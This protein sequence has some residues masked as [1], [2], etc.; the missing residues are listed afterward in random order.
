MD[1]RP[2]AGF[3]PGPDT[4]RVS[5]INIEWQAELG[6]C[7][8][9]KLPVAMMWVDTTLAGLISGIQAMVGT[10]RYLLALQSEGRKSVDADWQVISQFPDF[11][12]G[13]KAIANIAAVAG[14]GIWSLISLDP[15]KKECGFRIT[16]S[17]EGRYQ[18][19]LGV[20]WGS[21]MLAGKMA[22]YCTKLFGTN[23]W[24]DQVSFIA[25]GDGYDEFTVRPSLRSVE[26]EIENLLA[27]DEATRADMAVA[28]KRLENEIA[29][30]RRAEEMVRQGEERY[31]TVVEIT[32]TGY[33]VVGVHGQ[34]LDANQEYVR[35]TGHARLE[36]IMGRSVLEWTAPSETEKNRKAIEWCL[37]EGHI[38]GLEIDYVD[39]N[40]K[41][42]PIEINAAVMGAGDSRRI[43]T[44]CRDI[45]D[46]KKAAGILQNMQ[47]L[48]SLGV[49]AGGIAHDFNNLLSGIFGHIQLA[50]SHSEPGTVAETHL[51]KALSVFSRAR[52][53]T[54]QLLTFSKGGALVKKV[55][56]LP[57]LLRQ[58]TQFALSGSNV[59]VYYHLQADL[60]NVDAD[61]HQLSRAVENI[62]IN[63]CQAMPLGGA[64]TITANNIERGSAV[65]PVLSGGP[66]IGVSFRDQGVGIPGDILPHIFDPFFT[67][68]QQG[69]G[70]GLATSYSILR[71][72]G[73]HIDVESVPGKGTMFTLYLPAF[74]DAP[75][76]Q[77]SA[78]KDQN[79]KAGGTILLMDDEE[80]ILDVGKSMLEGRGYKVTPVHD[81]REAL[82]VY[83]QALAVGEPFDLVVLDITVPGG[84]GG[85]ETME[86]LLKLNPYV[87]A[88]A[89]SGYSEDPIIAEPRKFGFKGS[90]V[91][92]YLM[93]ELCE[94]IARMM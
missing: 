54:Q 74:L 76:A 26:K 46:R 68:K 41:M 53:L 87:I 88:V 59:T 21:G 62:I 92:P 25:D 3:S 32:D 2:Q 84:M 51:S 83:R 24:A 13:F 40:G 30:R 20:R 82:E 90:I 39:A 34:V 81:G 43:L 4:I 65:L 48:E 71:K 28:L 11:R 64:I 73:G 77:A 15:D 1:K 8:F 14:W 5:G 9:E 66:Y 57:E 55:V 49:L 58:V 79:V 18:K 91:K 27:T 17:W 19:A 35:L 16:N 37:K 50:Q 22:G 6:T 80:V 38:R 93:G 85:K 69:S 67:T 45:T 78:P 10:E 63:A 75:P 29:E 7:T 60:W 44:L 23:C 89:S 56:L 36:E 47:R 72:H 42:T 61:E 12:D 86:E 52:A 31:R 94:A 33:V 70:L